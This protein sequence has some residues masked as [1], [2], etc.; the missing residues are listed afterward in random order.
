MPINDRLLEHE[1][2]SLSQGTNLKY[3][4]HENISTY[5]IVTSARGGNPSVS[6][7][8]F[9]PKE[10]GCVANVRRSSRMNR[11]LRVHESQSSVTDKAGHESFPLTGGF[12]CSPKTTTRKGNSDIITT[13]LEGTVGNLIQ[14][15]CSGFD[16]RILLLGQ[17]GCGKSTFAF[18]SPAMET[19]CVSLFAVR[20]CLDTLS[21]T[22]SLSV[23]LWSH[24]KNGN[25]SDL[26]GN[27]AAN[28]TDLLGKDR[29]MKRSMAST[30]RLTTVSV[31]TED[32]AREVICAGLQ[33]SGN[34]SS[35]HKVLLS[36][37]GEVHVTLRLLRT[38]CSNEN[39]SESS[40]LV[41]DAVGSSTSGTPS[42]LLSRLPRQLNSQ[43]ISSFSLHYTGLRRLI[44]NS[45]DVQ[46]R[47]Q[48]MSAAKNNV[49]ASLIKYPKAAGIL[50]FPDFRWDTSDNNPFGPGLSRLGEII[51]LAPPFCAEGPMAHFLAP[52]L[53]S[54]LCGKR[55]ALV[56]VL[57][58]VST[59]D[60]DINETVETLNLL[61]QANKVSTSALRYDATLD[62]KLTYLESGVVFMPPVTLQAWGEILVKP[63][64]NGS[65]IK[66][67]Y[68]AVPY[69]IPVFISSMDLQP[70]LDN[71]VLPAS[72]EKNKKSEQPDSAD[73]GDTNVA[74]P[75]F[76]AINDTSFMAAL[77]QKSNLSPL[78]P[79]LSQS[80]LP[81]FCGHPSL[82]LELK[83]AA[84]PRPNSFVFQ[85]AGNASKLEHGALLNAP[86]IIV[87][88][89]FS[90]IGV[91]AGL[92]PPPSVRVNS[93]APSIF[94]VNSNT[95]SSR[96]Y[97]DDPFNRVNSDAPSAC[98]NSDALFVRVNN[99][100]TST[101]VYC[102][103]SSVKVNSGASCVC[104]NS[105]S[106]GIAVEKK[107]HK[108][109]FDIPKQAPLDIASAPICQRAVGVHHQYH[110]WTFDKGSI[111]NS[112]PDFV[113]P[114]P[115]LAPPP[116][117]PQPTRLSSEFTPY[118]LEKVLPSNNEES[119]LRSNGDLPVTI[120]STE[121]GRRRQVNT[122]IENNPGLPIVSLAA[123][124]LP[125]RS[126]PVRS[127]PSRPPKVASLAQARF[128]IRC[129]EESPSARLSPPPKKEKFHKRHPSAPPS[130]AK[131]FG[132]MGH[133]RIP[134]SKH[135]EQAR[136]ILHS[137][138]STIP[139]EMALTRVITPLSPKLLKSSCES[140]GG[141]ESEEASSSGE[142]GR[143]AIAAPV[144]SDSSPFPM[145]EDLFRTVMTESATS[146]SVSPVFS[147]Q[148]QTETLPLPTVCH[149]EVQTVSLDSFVLLDSTA[150]SLPPLPPLNFVN[151]AIQTEP[152]LQS[153][154]KDTP[155]LSP[156]LSSAPKPLDLSS[157]FPP[158]QLPS[159][160]CRA[161]PP[162]LRHTPGK[163]APYFPDSPSGPLRPIHPPQISSFPARSPRQENAPSRGSVLLSASPNVYN[164][165]V[166]PSL[167]NIPPLSFSDACVGA[168][169]VDKI[170][171][172]SKSET[173]EFSLCLPFH[174]VRALASADE[175]LATKNKELKASQTRVNKLEDIVLDLSGRLTGVIAALRS[176]TV[177]DGETDCRDFT[178][179]VVTGQLH[180]TQ[181]NGPVESDF[182]VN[183]PTS[184]SNALFD[185]IT[186]PSAMKSLAAAANG[187][188]KKL[189]CTLSLSAA[190]SPLSSDPLTPS[191]SPGLNYRAGFFTPG[192]AGE[193][194]TS[195]IS[196]FVTSNESVVIKGAELASLAQT[197]RVAECLLNG[198][199]GVLRGQ[200]KESRHRCAQLQFK[201]EALE[202]E[203]RRV[204]L[205]KR[206][207]ET[208]LR[209][210]E[211][212]K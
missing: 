106:K 98:V 82:F 182:V 107:T 199:L 164:S 40:L 4:R 166:L 142:D 69:T 81:A 151:T 200:L 72:T 60:G 26:L 127:L 124:L 131:S 206:F 24:D 62:S 143:E 97:S 185:P 84:Y 156:I 14:D 56:S 111:F 44:I 175:M 104:A 67:K 201:L 117:P 177:L 190:P 70:L 208:A 196:S 170:D 116:S 63:N 9:E 43:S 209:R 184:N 163:D 38:A 79:S 17:R 85:E 94:V 129:L 58:V 54:D 18:G 159:T 122:D 92:L 197:V 75:L 71:V 115:L 35:E 126:R 51:S 93:D 25:L 11:A 57:G 21:S 188:A 28:T 194:V 112:G 76:P 42:S 119:D 171:S 34:F 65:L 147:T 162:P 179:E 137:P 78:I 103:A 160:P 133:E 3:T 102:D 202:P 12:F 91:Q 73:S 83:H 86:A 125:R 45:S 108:E 132:R 13:V 1:L 80:P 180:G 204:A 52:I 64:F 141:T 46:G 158:P 211:H 19:P 135:A 74:L 145:S 49:S 120:S 30:L 7:V 32:E 150:S 178:G 169:V 167:E 68:D 105:D 186:S 16:A 5:G 161:S 183:A 153:T 154:Q 100:I 181:T 61:S 90:S 205:Y 136:L 152:V 113:S 207:A 33:A 191:P 210:V 27:Q 48:V 148:T 55:G 140:E 139:M 101:H 41:F 123:T 10:S 36:C 130:L 109:V 89:S 99:D 174:A 157:T 8:E 110:N 23:S 134:V 195:Q 87:N 77:R 53:S 37:P 187:F 47:G 189:R 39:I 118:V 203:L 149:V 96:I 128:L 29:G 6:T 22:G 193:G 176:F 146:P 114:P 173:K 172:P 15:W 192:L 31:R 66:P 212:P 198:G 155:P 95:T 20:K 88:S 50:N 59:D 138:L 168:N 2:L 144:F 121:R 165:P